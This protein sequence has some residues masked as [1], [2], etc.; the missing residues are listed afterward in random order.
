MMVETS[1]LAREV[2]I[3]ADEHLVPRYTKKN[4]Y[5]KGGQRKKSTNVFEASRSCPNIHT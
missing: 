2:I 1:R 4:G 3:A 5:S